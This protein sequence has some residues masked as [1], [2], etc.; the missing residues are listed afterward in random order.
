MSTAGSFTGVASG[1]SEAAASGF[2]VA[3]TLIESVG[4]GACAVDAECACSSPAGA[5][6]CAADDAGIL[7]PGSGLESKVTVGCCCTCIAAEEAVDLLVDE[8]A[9]PDDADGP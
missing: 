3:A 1:G 6:C 8:A 2:D 5:C 9:A 4:A 7:V